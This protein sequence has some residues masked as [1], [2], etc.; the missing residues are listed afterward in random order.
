M[1]G[2]MVSL[3]PLGE[4][5]EEGGDEW[6]DVLKSIFSAHHFCSLLHPLWIC[7]ILAIF[8]HLLRPDGLKCMCVVVDS[9]KIRAKI[10]M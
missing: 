7:F 6:V 9:V 10:L 8:V 5:C 4:R 2:K 1:I 3:L